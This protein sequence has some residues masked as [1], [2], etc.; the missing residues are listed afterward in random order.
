MVEGMHL[1]HTSNLWAVDIPTVTQPTMSIKLPK[2]MEG[3]LECSSRC[4]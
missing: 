4:R 1:I 3:T 2:D